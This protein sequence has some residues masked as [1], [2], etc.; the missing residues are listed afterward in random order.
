[1]SEENKVVESMEEETLYMTLSFDDGQEE[2]CEVLGVFDLDGK[3]YVA[4]LSP[5]EDVYIYGYKQVGE[6][7][8]ELL[9]IETEEEFDKVAA[10]YDEITAAAE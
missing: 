6:D 2:D 5:E 9:D 10:R 1:M 3:E 8:F 7:E 4:L